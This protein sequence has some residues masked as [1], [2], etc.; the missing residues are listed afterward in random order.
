MKKIAIISATIL[1]LTVSAR[2]DKV[3]AVIGGTTG[4]LVAGPPGAII[5]LLIG[6]IWGSPWWGTPEPEFKCWIDDNFQRH[7]PKMPLN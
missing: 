3:G 1:A 5:G 7:C 2:A 6:G 4:L